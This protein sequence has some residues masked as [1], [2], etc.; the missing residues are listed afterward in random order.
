M[1]N[2]LSGWRVFK[3]NSWHLVIS[4]AHYSLSP[5]MNPFPIWLAIGSFAG[6]L[7]SFR[8]VPDTST[9]AGLRILQ[10]VTAVTLTFLL[11]VMLGPR[12]LTQLYAFRPAEQPEERDLFQGVHYIREVRR[13]PHPMVIHVIT[14]DL[15][16]PGIAFAVTS[17]DSSAGMEVLAQ[18]TSAFLFVNQTQIAI[19]ADG[20]GPWHDISPLDYYPHSGD[21]VD[22]AG[23]AA[24]AGDIYS[25]ARIDFPTLF[26]SED[27]TVSFEKPAGTVYNA[28]SGKNMLI[29]NG[30]LIGDSPSYYD[31]RHPRTAVGLD[32]TGHVL[33]LVVVD[34]R[35]PG[36]SVGASMS[37]LADIMLFYGSFTA[38][39]LDGGGSSTLVIEQNG[40]PKVLNS[41][42][43]NYIPYRERPIANHLGVYALPLN[44]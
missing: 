25:E 13:S 17:P 44:R 12:L 35:Q 3:Y 23:Y 18:T 11:I 43:H 14:I 38:L 30:S 27:S 7:I 32:A 24:S 40:G 29:R 20:W 2:F 15:N 9:R 21:P 42:I 26:I 22:V 39:N 19:N 4:T 28:V 5:L 41:P 6:L 10:I 36:Y 34:G 37:E 8:R 31:Q 16:A 1:M 33:I